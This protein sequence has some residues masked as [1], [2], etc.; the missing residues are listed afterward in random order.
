MKVFKQK[1]I[2]ISGSLN[3][4]I[5]Y[6]SNHEKAGFVSF[7]SKDIPLKVVLKVDEVFIFKVKN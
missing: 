1:A 3:G 4:K 7:Y 5:G 2:V 6:V